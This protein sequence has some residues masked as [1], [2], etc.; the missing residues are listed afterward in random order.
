MRIENSRVAMSASR[1]YKAETEVTQTHIDRY[2]NADGSVGG[3]RVTQTASRTRQLQLSGEAASYSRTETTPMD[4][5]N[6]QQT[7]ATQTAVLPEQQGDDWLTNLSEGIENDPQVIMLRKLLDLLERFTGKKFNHDPLGLEKG[8]SGSGQFRFSASAASARY[9]QTALLFGAQELSP[10]GQGGQNGYWTR[11]T[12]ESGFAAGEEHT[13]FT[14]TGTVQTSDGRTLNFGISVEMSRSFEMAY[15]VTGQE[16]VFTDPLV[17]NLDTDAASLSDVSFYF[18]LDGDGV[19]EEMS[20]LKEGSGF[21]ALDKNGDG[22]INDGSELFGARTGDG[23]G[24]LARYDQDGNGWIDEN[25]AVFSK[26]SVWVKCGSGESR[27][28]SLKEANVG[29]IF[30]GSRGTQYSL[31]DSKGETQGMIRRSGV[32]LKET[33]Q[34][35]TVQHVDFKT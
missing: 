18:D 2:H 6:P 15:E 21:L 22:E 14:S 10:G 28:L 4:P 25:D 27:L 7:A 24:E 33:G 1:T 17:I 8:Q 13:A 20:G 3:V 31:D 5:D 26:L 30:L 23:F 32:Y 9:Q 11:Q 16:A 19:K 12:V 35:G 34:V 29:A